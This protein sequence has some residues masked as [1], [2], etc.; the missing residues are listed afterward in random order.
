MCDFH[1]DWETVE[2]KINETRTFP[3][4]KIEI[5]PKIPNLI[6]CYVELYDGYTRRA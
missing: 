3:I 2:K 1:D 5:L 6:P 4:G